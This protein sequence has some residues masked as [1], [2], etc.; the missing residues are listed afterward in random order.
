M[1]HKLNN[2][3]LTLLLLIVGIVIISGL[4]AAM[5]T[6]Y[7]TSTISEINDIG[8]LNAYYLAESGIRYAKLKPLSVGTSSTYSLNSSGSTISIVID[9]NEG[10]TST[11]IYSLNSGLKSTRVLYDKSCKGLGNVLSM[12]GNEIKKDTAGN[13]VIDNSGNQNNGYV[14][15]VVKSGIEPVSLVTGMVGNAL[16]FNC[17]QYARVVFSDINPYDI[18]YSGTIMLW[19]N[20]STFSHDVAGLVHKGSS[21]ISC[22]SSDGTVSIFTDEVYTLQFYPA[23]RNSVEL[24][25]SIIDGSSYNGKCDGTWNYI[26][27]TSNTTF[28]NSNINTWYLVAVTWIYDSNTNATKLIMYINGK[29]DSQTDWTKPFKP[30][31]N[32]SPLIVGSQQN[33]NRGDADTYFC[34]VIDE[35]NVYNYPL[36]QSQIS[37]YYNSIIK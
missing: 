37:N 27:I 16:K 11:G 25:F 30:R 10:T 9:A 23:S 29:L 4:S 15:G 20:A 22:P 5:V 7:N 19:F 26:P 12:S 8:Y 2:G 33:S 21:T 28:N 24:L 1:Y 35:V 6:F 3:G 31:S 34:G 13:Y 17:N 14:Y 32:D 36:T 18:Y